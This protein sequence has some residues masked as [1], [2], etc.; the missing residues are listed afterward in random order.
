M[1]PNPH[2]YAK[3][4]KLKIKERKKSIF[5]INLFFFYLKNFL[6][7]NLNSKETVRVPSS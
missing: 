4:K 1:L 7:T 2:N 3:T 6:K 5:L